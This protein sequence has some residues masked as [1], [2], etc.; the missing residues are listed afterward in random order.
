MQQHTTVNSL[1]TCYVNKMMFKNNTLI[2]GYKTIPNA[3]TVKIRQQYW[4]KTNRDV[5]NF[6]KYQPER[7]EKSDTSKHTI[8]TW[9]IF[10]YIFLGNEARNGKMLFLFFHSF[11][12]VEPDHWYIQLRMKNYPMLTSFW[13]TLW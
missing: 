13:Q 6:Y 1:N 8:S 10:K 9:R 3:D 2:L 11:S 5:V 4:W 12:C 7:K